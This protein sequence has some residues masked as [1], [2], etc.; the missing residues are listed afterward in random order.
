MD[1]EVDLGR[2]FLSFNLVQV[3]FAELKDAVPLNFRFT[4]P[5]DPLHRDYVGPE[6]SITNEITGSWHAEL[7]GGGLLPLTEKLGLGV[8]AGVTGNLFEPI[9]T[10]LLSSPKPDM[11]VT[12]DCDLTC[13]VNPEDE[14]EVTMDLTA[15]TSSAG[16]A[17]FLLSKDE[18]GTLTEHASA[19]LSGGAASTTWAPSLSDLGKYEAYP[20]IAIDT[21]SNSYPY[22]S[23]EGRGFYVGTRFTKLD[24]NGDELPQDAAAWSCVRDNQEGL[25]WESKTDDGG[26]R[27]RD[28][29]YAW[30]DPDPA[31]NGGFAGCLHP[32]FHPAQNRYCLNPSADDFC[33]QENCNS[34]DY[35][36]AMNAS[37]YCNSD[38]WR[39]PTYQ[40]LEELLIYELVFHNHPPDREFGIDL[41]LFPFTSGEAPYQ[42][43]KTAWSDNTMLSPIDFLPEWDAGDGFWYLD[44]RSL[45]KNEGGHLRLVRDAQ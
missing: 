15:G 5:F 22:A 28:W 8:S 14:D 19:S 24:E 31:T 18:S 38:S 12:M 3:K 21:L 45:Y 43:T 34:Y 29:R 33:P 37:G 16:T 2:S 40:E 32:D 4:A 10:P 35:A 27:D 7:S 25:V 9:S 1:L 6:W 36:A 30:Y 20:R 26:L 39:V 11:A 42:T 23:S 41:D 17:Q 13:Q 44:F